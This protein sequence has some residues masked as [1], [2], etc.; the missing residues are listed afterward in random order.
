MEYS[1]LVPYSLDLRDENSCLGCNQGG[2][3]LCGANARPRDELSLARGGGG[4]QRLCSGV[5]KEGTGELKP[6]LLL[7]KH[8][9]CGSNSEVLI[10]PSNSGVSAQR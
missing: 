5:L 8:Q 9:G 6:R 3:N 2:A 4:K 7:V 10:R 1:L